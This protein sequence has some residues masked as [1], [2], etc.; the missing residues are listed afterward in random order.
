M[1][2]YIIKSKEVGMI[3]IQ[4]KEKGLA[5]MASKGREKTRECAWAAV[6]EPGEG[7]QLAPRRALPRRA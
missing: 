7:K 4:N 1:L 6:P 2:F 5:L 3:K